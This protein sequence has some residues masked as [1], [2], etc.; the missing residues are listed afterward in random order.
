MALASEGGGWVAGS[1]AVILPAAVSSSKKV[2][3]IAAPEPAV[4]NQ[5]LVADNPGTQKVQC[6]MF[7]PIVIS[8]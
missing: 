3:T 2:I 8:T 4:D 5:I 6:E 7:C 1:D